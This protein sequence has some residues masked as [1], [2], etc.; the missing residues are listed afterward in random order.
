MLSKDKNTDIILKKAPP[1]LFETIK[2]IFKLLVNGKIPLRNHHRHKLSKHASFIRDNIKG[3][4]SQVKRNISQKG[5][6][7]GSV[8]KTIL[9][10]VSPILSLLI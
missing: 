7:L 9:P 8:L 1:K 4:S 10:V 5:G 2:L 6:S 3:N